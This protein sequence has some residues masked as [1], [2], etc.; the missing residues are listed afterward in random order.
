MMPSGTVYCAA[1]LLTSTYHQVVPFT[2]IHTTFSDRCCKQHSNSKYLLWHVAMQE[3]CKQ[4]NW[5][6]LC[7]HFWFFFVGPSSS[8]VGVIFL[9]CQCSRLSGSECH[10][11]FFFVHSHG[12]KLLCVH[13]FST[14][15]C[16]CDVAFLLHKISHR[17]SPKCLG[18]TENPLKSLGKFLL[19][20]FGSQLDSKSSPPYQSVQPKLLFALNVLSTLNQ[21][22]DLWCGTSRVWTPRLC[23][24]KADYTL[25]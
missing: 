1:L 24:L 20:I 4:T 23:V 3:E 9:F 22:V 21:S 18:N 13:R 11:A 10:V 19:N 7:T 12:F 17:A 16:L 2:S 25:V 8:E 5:L 15:Y 6:L 14:M